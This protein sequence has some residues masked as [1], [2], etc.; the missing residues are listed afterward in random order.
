MRAAAAL[1][2]LSKRMLPLGLSLL[3]LLLWLALTATACLPPALLL[4]NLLCMAVLCSTDGKRG[5]EGTIEPT[6]A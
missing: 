3:A 1:A 5:G 4:P 2:L 6:A